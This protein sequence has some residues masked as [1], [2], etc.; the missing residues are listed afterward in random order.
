M[1][2]KS[3]FGNS[4]SSS[5]LS[6]PYDVAPAHHGGSF[7]G[8]L[9]QDTI[10]TAKGIPFGLVETAKHPIRMGK[11][12][13]KETAHEYSP[14]VH[15]DFKTFWHEFHAHPLQPL[16]DAV[17]IPALALGGA[18][19]AI[20]GA[21]TVAELG[22]AGEI[23]DVLARA[24]DLAAA[25]KYAEADALK[26]S[27]ARSPGL[28]K[29]A[30]HFR[31]GTSATT[32]MYDTPIPGVQLA[33]AYSTNLF[34]RSL[35]RG[36]D[37]I[38]ETGAKAKL[39]VIGQGKALDA[40]AEGV[41]RRMLAKDI[42]KRRAAT[43]AEAKAQALILHHAAK[44][45]VPVD[46]AAQALTDR[47]EHSVLSMGHKISPDN[48]EKLAGDVAHQHYQFVAAAQGMEPDVGWMHEP[49]QRGLVFHQGEKPA[50][51]VA[52]GEATLEGYGKGQ[53]KEFIQTL[54]QRIKYTNDPAKAWV[55]EHGMVTVVRKGISDELKRQVEG[56]AD[57][58]GQIARSPLR[59]WKFFVLAGAPRYF[60]NN[61]IGNAGMYAAATNP[62][63]FTRGVLE[64][65]RSVRGVRA[66]ARMERQMN[67]ELDGLMAKYLP[68]DVVA[69]QFAFLQ[70]GSLGLDQ[71]I[72]FGQSGALKGGL[73]TGLYHAT[74]KI[75]YRGPQRAAIMGALGS[76][77]EV[78]DLARVYRAEGKSAEESFQLAAA[79]ALRDKRVQAAVE[80]KVTD[81]AGQYYHMN[82]LEQK[83]TALVPFYNWD[84]H[85]V[86]FAKEQ[87]LDRPAQSAVLSREGSQGNTDADKALGKIPDF[88]KGA[89][90]VGGHTGGVLGAILG[91]NL[92]GRKKVIL[93][94]GYNPLAAAAEDVHA[95]A[96][97]V[98]AHAPGEAIGGQLNP[99]VSGAIAGITGQRVFS[100]ARVHHKGG[101]V[102][103]AAAETFGELPQIT[104]I[105][106]LI[107]G[108]PQ[109][110]PNKQ[111]GKTKPFLYSKDTRQVL[112][113][114]LGVS[115]RDF[116]PAAA[117]ALYDKQN[118]IKKGRRH[119]RRMA[120][121]L[122]SQL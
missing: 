11:L 28:Y 36:S 71:S 122:K 50:T 73:K 40:S 118:G 106:R 37:A 84:R 72:G 23:G 116:S 109:P 47:F 4:S 87:V 35:Q 8:N 22:R 57:L 25:G 42:S 17:S 120:S 62:V 51:G 48:A 90:P 68:E 100:G 45:G 67:G 77:K 119:A 79:K 44:K 112:S 46:T 95:L 15:G 93:T 110:K 88:L 9:L 115:E 41:G 66:A 12:T 10:D 65:V 16:I 92:P 29:A 76:M 97:L 108:T 63:E 86:R 13:V 5:A 53:V 83:L 3:A 32:R 98:G 34:R 39:P 49:G 26:T 91:G 31:R 30:A 75:A 21:S 89:V 19:A 58:T 121:S 99:L 74:E 85:A 114:L 61:V 54:G 103:S 6:M 107:E 82:G 59:V 55:D 24:N 117:K 81:W 18:G 56:S 80:K 64:A 1:S 60:V 27:A 96:A 7:F 104:L 2:F 105:K 43:S 101:V 20:K 78:R 14:L 33:K 113:S 69:R 52:K 70:H 94:S 38:L 111:T 102:G